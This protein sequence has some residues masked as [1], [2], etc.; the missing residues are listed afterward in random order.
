MS[1]LNKCPI[2]QKAT[3]GRKL[4][5]GLKNKLIQYKFP[6]SSGNAR[7]LEVFS[8]PHKSPDPTH[9]NFNSPKKSINAPTIYS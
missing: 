8:D 4:S 3:R 9:L 2:L 6:N 7:T 5:S 1:I